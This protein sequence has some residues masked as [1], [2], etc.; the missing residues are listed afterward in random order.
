MLQAATQML[1]STPGTVRPDAIE[2]TGEIEGEVDWSSTVERRL[3][4]GDD[5]LFVCRFGRRRFETPATR[6]VRTALSMAEGI[7]RGFSPDSSEVGLHREAASER[8]HHLTRHPK[9]NGVR[10]YKH[11]TE[12]QLN[13]ADQRSGLWPIVSYIRFVREVDA[14]DPD[15][16]ARLL[17]E[18]VTAPASDDRIFE[19]QVGFRLV[20][21]LIGAGWTLELLQAVAG[22]RLPF[23]RLAKDEAS[24]VIWQ[25]RALSTLPLQVGQSRYSEYRRLNGL[26]S[27]G[28]IPDY[29]IEH[30]ERVML[31]EVKL[32]T[33]DTLRGASDHVKAGLIDVMAYLHDYPIITE[34]PLPRA[35]VVAWGTAAAPKVESTVAVCDLHQL[36]FIADQF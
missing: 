6:L 31:L 21:E 1:R 19:L 13:R 9:L 17:D 27:S 20:E 14:R 10:P 2:L 26:S 15:A 7:G 5:T 29:V 22:S 18:V 3:E 34:G 4:T 33:R 12:E 28:L 11:I 23:A 35:V 16:V 32:T 30:Q 24:L 25:Q 8:A 36:G